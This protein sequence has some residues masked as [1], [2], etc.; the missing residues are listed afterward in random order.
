MEDIFKKRE[1]VYNGG[2]EKRV[3]SSVLSDDER[4]GR[5]CPN[6]LDLFGG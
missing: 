6:L 5:Y 3:L 4:T 2:H 1:I